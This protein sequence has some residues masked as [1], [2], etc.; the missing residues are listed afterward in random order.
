MSL[1]AIA[2]WLSELSNWTLFVWSGRLL[3]LLFVPLVLLERSARPLSAV[4]WILALLFVPYLGVIFWWLV[5]RNH[6]ERTRRRR[7]RLRRLHSRRMEEIDGVSR[8]DVA[9]P[10]ALYEEHGLFPPTHS[11]SVT[12]FGDATQAFDAFAS[13]IER[14]EDH[15]HLLF[16]VWKPDQTGRRF[17]DLLTDAA[18][19]GVEVRAL[20][21][22]VGSVR[23]SR[24]F[25]SPIE[26]AGG[27]V[28]P[29]LPVR[30][31]EPQ[32]R[33]NFRNH[34]KFLIVDGR[35][36]FTGGVNLA[37][38][39]LEWFDTAYGFAGGVVHQMQE[40][41]AEDWYFA[42]GEDLADAR[43]VPELSDGDTLKER[44][45]QLLSHFLGGP[46]PDVEG[47]AAR[48]V[49][50]GPDEQVDR[51][52]KMFFQG[53]NSA[54]QRLHII[55]PYFVP[56]YAILT[57]LETAALAGIDVR[58]IIPARSDVPL[59]QHAGR[60]Y[61][62]RLLLVGVRLYEYRRR[63]LHTKLMLVDDDQVIVGSANMDI[64]S[65]RLNFEANCV[66]ESKEMNR[67]LH[68]LFFNALNGSDEID[69][70]TFRARP[71]SARFKEGT[72]RLFSPLL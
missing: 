69:L 14:A 6:F 59:T 23:M 62:E 48:M 44:S 15:V 3:G 55:T 9:P 60:F 72:A 8:A 68:D 22:Y 45:P 31:W 49:A 35:C 10:Q 47:A 36:G 50:S 13:A 66:L 33:A 41:F 39:Y 54:R 32:S 63:V 37:D 4:A 12:I 1:L 20:Y 11:N 42:T 70:E 53:I 52:H 26:E 57:A 34:R 65:F 38:E 61:W 5:G 51:V 2:A 64:R 40:L 18:R 27:R 56:D 71:F 25:L 21:D 67:R 29:F 7:A 19:R 30:L 58:I 43:Y 28:A 46:A 24:S 17:R 16:Y